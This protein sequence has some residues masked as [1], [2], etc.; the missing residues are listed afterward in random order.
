MSSP[1]RTPRLCLIFAMAF[2]FATSCATTVH[3]PM[4]T[5]KDQSAST[6]NRLEAVRMLDGSPEDPAYLALLRSLV[7]EWGVVQPVRAAA[8]DRLYQYDRARL[9]ELVDLRLAKLE[10]LE[11]R[12][13]ICDRIAELDWK[14]ATPALVRALARPMKGWIRLLEERPE[15][16]AIAKMWGNEKVPDV[17]FDLLLTSNP[18][19]HANLRARCWELLIETKHEDRLIELLVST[20]PASTDAMLRDLRAGWI[21]LGVLPLTREEVI[22]LRTLR[23]PEHA[24]FWQQAV[25]ALSKM[26]ASTKRTMRMKDIAVAAAAATERPDLL[27]M[28]RDSIVAALG[29]RIET[30]GNR[31]H[32]PD[33][34]GF[35][36]DRSERFS[37]HRKALTWGDAAAMLVMFEALQD[38]NVVGHFFQIA[39]RDHSDRSTEYGGIVRLDGQGRVELVEFIPSQRGN[40]LQFHA[41]QAMFDAG[42]TVIGHFHFHAC[43]FENDRHAGP[44]MGDFGYADSTGANG[45]V[46][47]FLDSTKL[48]VDWYRRGEV[49]VD[50]GTVERP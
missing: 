12:R 17:I 5:L 7:F 44:H 20:E 30:N 31:V 11:W 1:S 47:S 8:F 16:L 9:L 3:D 43:E 40:D 35:G 50:L 4:A 38:P 14:E 26:D 10:A 33:F 6:E 2:A 13:A 24:A 42:Y 25:E 18:V 29:A 39:D 34:Q 21:D 19:T 36:G 28:N 37:D 23:Q 27:L 32:S 49:A 45:F 48:N 22:W 46:F 41:S 15:Y